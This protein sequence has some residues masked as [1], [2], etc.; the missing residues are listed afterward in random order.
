MYGAIKNPN[1]DTDAKR[2]SLTI[3]TRPMGGERE[4]RP[5]DVVAFALSPAVDFLPVFCLARPTNAPHTHTHPTARPYLHRA[6]ESRGVREAIGRLYPPPSF[7]L[8]LRRIKKWRNGAPAETHHS[9]G[10]HAQLS[11]G[12]NQSQMRY[13][14]IGPAT[15]SQSRKPINPPN[16]R[17]N[18]TDAHF[19]SVFQFKTF[20]TD[21]GEVVEV[22][23]RSPPN[24][25]NLTKYTKKPPIRQI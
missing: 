6:P 12:A 21:S 14:G 20:P 22:H 24:A 1:I 8:P 18:P 15:S 2:I 23:I 7:P 16:Q 5:R 4:A 25:G 11:Q 13:G 3:K 9:Q 17:N 19:E 10:A